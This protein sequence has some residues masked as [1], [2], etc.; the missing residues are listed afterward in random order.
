MSEVN[1]TPEQLIKRVSIGVR[2]SSVIPMPIDPTLSNEGEAADAKA[3]GDAIAAVI[4]E[5][6]V[7]EKAPVN[8][9]ITL[10]ATDIVMSSEEGAQTIA[11]AVEAAGDKDAAD[12]MYD[13]ENLVTVADA[14]D[15]INTTLDSEL[16][17]EQIDEIFED[18]FGEDEE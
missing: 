11:E 14:L 12:I 15:A 18:V 8:K 7:N 16:T 5:L 17:E 6:R 4:G 9:K 13:A 10:Y 2:S 3:T 1:A